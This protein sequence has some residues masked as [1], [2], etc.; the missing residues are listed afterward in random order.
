MYTRTDAAMARALNQGIA[1]DA[2]KGAANAWTYMKHF[3]VPQQVIL[4]VL[5]EPALRRQ[6]KTATPD[7]PDAPVD[8]N[9]IHLWRK[10]DG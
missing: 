10:P 6:H 3:R 4:R 5:A 7:Q 2:A 8:D 1:I 9:I